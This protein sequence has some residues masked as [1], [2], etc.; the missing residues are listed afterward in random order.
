MDK[1]IYNCHVHTFTAASVPDRFLPLGLNRI[2]KYRIFRRSI[3]YFIALVKSVMGFLGLLFPSPLTKG[4]SLFYGLIEKAW[5]SKSSLNHEALLRYDQFFETGGSGSQR[6]IFERLRVQYPNGTHFVVLP[7]DMEFMGAGKPTVRYEDQLNEL[8]LLRDAFPDAVIPFFAADPRRPNLLELFH[9]YVGKRGFR[10]VKLY[11]NLGY[12]PN[13][14]KLLEIYALCQAKKIPVLAHCS[15]GGIRRKGLSAAQAKNFAHPANYAEVLKDFPRLN[16][17]LAHFGGA[18]EWERQITG[19]APREGEE[20]S[21]LS[22]ILKMLTVEKYPNLYTDISYTM[23][24]RT[25]SDRAFNYFDY[26]KVLL[27]DPLVAEHVLFG[28]DYYMVEQEK[29]SE[30]EVSIALRSRL[31]E[32]LYFQIAHKNPQVYLYEVR[33]ARAKKKRR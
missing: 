30:K 1:P 29:F 7:M 32:K 14:S 5:L 28:T 15:P 33:P 4:I 6:A 26:L 24:A 23:F 22:V 9:E 10:G 27:S 18:E 25:P 3:I 31:G 11:P 2:L 16:I 20:E 19:K 21:W 8:A 13:D 12:F 17:C